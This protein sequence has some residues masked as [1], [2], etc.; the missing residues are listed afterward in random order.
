VRSSIEPGVDHVDEEAKGIEQA[1]DPGRTQQQGTERN[2][3]T[4]L[5]LEGFPFHG[6]GS[7]S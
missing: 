4:E 2:V 1:E 6:Y 3:L 7:I 5:A